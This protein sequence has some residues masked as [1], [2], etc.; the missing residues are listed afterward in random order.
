M[1]IFAQELFRPAKE[2]GR[3]DGGLSFR[4]THVGGRSAEPATERSTEVGHVVEYMSRHRFRRPRSP[5]FAGRC[6]D[7]NSVRRTPP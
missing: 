3:F 4:V 6:A 5:M 2:Y 7:E 1:L